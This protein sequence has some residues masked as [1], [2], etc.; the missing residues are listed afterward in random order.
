M[1]REELEKQISAILRTYF[2]LPYKTV[3]FE[4][5]SLIEQKPDCYEKEFCRWLLVLCTIEC[6]YELWE[7]LKEMSLYETFDYWQTNIKEK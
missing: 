1:T 7:L 3:A 5:A 2:G 4:I 6:D